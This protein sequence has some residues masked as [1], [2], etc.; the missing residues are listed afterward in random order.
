[1]LAKAVSRLLPKRTLLMAP[2]PLGVRLL[3]QADDKIPPDIPE[4]LVG[5]DGKIDPEK[6][7]FYGVRISAS[8]LVTI[9]DAVRYVTEA[10][11][12]IPADM[13]IYLVE[14]DGKIV[15]TLRP[16]RGPVGPEPRWPR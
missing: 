3:T 10:D 16:M 2:S 13:A 12:E 15:Y 5:K 1:M 9:D 14:K 6:E 7:R 11:T 8:P 4:F